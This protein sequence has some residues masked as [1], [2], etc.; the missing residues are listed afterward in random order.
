MVRSPAPAFN[1]LRVYRHAAPYAHRIRRLAEFKDV[2]VELIPL[3]PDKIFGGHFDDPTENLF[4]VTYVTEDAL[5]QAHQA[6]IDTSYFQA[7]K[8]K[9]AKLVS[10]LDGYFSKA[11]VGADQV[12]RTYVEEDWGTPA[13]YAYLICF[14]VRLVRSTFWRVQGLVLRVGEGERV[15]VCRGV[16]ECTLL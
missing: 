2:E 6:G 3:W 15:G 7:S 16:G 4:K 14:C 12:G 10:E 11:K 1:G 13:R 5:R 8:D 9:Y